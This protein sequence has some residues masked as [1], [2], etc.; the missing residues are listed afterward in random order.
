MDVILS[1]KQP[2]FDA[3]A[4]MVAAQKLYP[5]S[6]I[7][8]DGKYSGRV[9]DFLSLAKD[10][11]P[12]R[13]PKDIDSEQVDRI[14][15][16]D[17][18]EL[19][20][21]GILAEKLKQ[22]PGLKIEIFDHHPYHE[23]KTEGIYIETLGACTTLLVER[24]A[25]LGLKLSSFEATLLALGIYEDTGSFLFESTTVRDIRA[26]AYLL[27]QGA[28]LSVI[29]EY[30]RK[31]ITE[32]QKAILQQLLDH[33]KR[34]II[35]GQPV[36]LT[37]AQHD[38]YI[39][40]LA[41][42]AHRIGEIEGVDTWFL[43]VRMNERI[44]LIG[45]STGQGMNINGVIEAF[46][47]SGHPKAASATIKG[48]DTFSVLAKLREEIRQRVYQR[49]LVKDIMSHPVKCVSPATKLADV[50]HML[51]RYGHTGVPVV[52][53]E[54]HLLGII[55]RRD[56]EKAVK[57][58]LQHAPV[59][60]FMT[61]G[62]ITIDADVPWDEAQRLM[63]RHDIGR[64]PVLLDGQLVGIISRSDVLRQLHGS[65]VPIE[66]ALAHQRSQAMRQDILQLIGE[67]P[68]EI[69]TILE[70]VCA[71]A[72]Q[73]KCQVYLVG[74]FIRDLL[75][76]I[77]NHDL[78]ITVEGSG[79]NFA[80]ALAKRYEGKE[81]ALYPEFGTA[82]LD[83]GGDMYV[84]VAST[85]QEYYAF[86]GALPQVEESSL[87]N[88]LFRRD[89]TI[90]AMAVC[91][92]SGRFGELVDYYGG[93]RDLQ[94]GEIRLLHRLSFIDDPTRMLRAIRFAV[95]YDFVL[96][97]DTETAMQSAVSA[98]ILHKISTERFTEE[99]RLIYMEP[100]YGEMG[101]RLLDTRIFRH[102]FGEELPWNFT[103]AGFEEVLTEFNQRWLFSL[104]HMT[105]EQ[106]RVVMENIQLTKENRFHTERLGK[107]RECL[108]QCRSLSEMDRLLE[109][110]PR[111]QVR[112]LQ[113]APE[114][115]ESVQTYERALDDLRMSVSGSRLL[116]RG[117]K[118]G[119]KIG[120]LL[121]EIREAWLEGKI[122]TPEEE[123]EYLLKLEG[124]A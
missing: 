18:S 47:G 41:L 7:V 111:W 102:W 31:P 21:V 56:V 94:Q 65:A 36:Y 25:G 59:T 93:L 50:E 63:V 95:R 4:S 13:T 15:L 97:K 28:Q 118:R 79:L 62:V 1:H 9:Q 23:K 98:G 86:S 8:I 116:E 70:T 88:D 113:A 48:N 82:R 54:K 100:K 74:G 30:L 92:N 61:T 45:R 112:L 122:R 29:S 24:L 75:L 90:N 57:H 5:D 80:S 104:I 110:L 115:K 114:L 87:R 68:R 105:E 10:M 44:Y 99:I 14:I 89:F 103:T 117:I 91:L 37:E 107:L 43:A 81:L 73:E 96:S 42:L 106:I 55:S 39:G 22:K 27:E 33:G 72:D 101:K 17:T 32:E 19:S 3:L 69:R 35:N 119:P 12:I 20:R 49:Y 76:K 53:E 108:L 40:G 38:E 85:R 121:R 11:L 123:E 120:R 78:D 77:P 60:G 64:L 34:E 83:F 84:D 52:N 67:L 51:L 46:G 26:A 6:V 109:K 2:D 71:V 66:A 16:V 58:G 124:R